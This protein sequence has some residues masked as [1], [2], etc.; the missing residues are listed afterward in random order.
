MPETSWIS[1]SARTDSKPF[2]ARIRGRINRVALASPGRAKWP[3]A[4]PCRRERR[5]LHKAYVKAALA[6]P[7]PARKTLIKLHLSFPK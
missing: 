6:F 2:I 4:L 1:C 3:K 7:A 5:D